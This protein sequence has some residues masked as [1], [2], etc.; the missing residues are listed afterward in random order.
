MVQGDPPEHLAEVSLR[1]TRLLRLGGLAGFQAGEKTPRAKRWE[2]RDGFDWILIG[3]HICKDAKLMLMHFLGTIYFA[4]V[5]TSGWN[6][7]IFQ[8]EGYGSQ[9]GNR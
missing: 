3:G 1:L 2:K 6:R 5:V 9:N 8:T 7:C 4:D